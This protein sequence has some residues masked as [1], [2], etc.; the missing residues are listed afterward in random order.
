MDPS[1]DAYGRLTVQNVEYADRGTYSCNVSNIH[2]YQIAFAELQVQGNCR[3]QHTH[4]HDTHI[5][6]HTHTHNTHTTHTHRHTHT[7]VNT[8][9]HIHPHT[10]MHVIWICLE[11]FLGYFI[12]ILDT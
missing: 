1:F 9:T 11:Y 2:E 3:T 10:H 5:N 7:H 12:I 4:T 6:T 8:H